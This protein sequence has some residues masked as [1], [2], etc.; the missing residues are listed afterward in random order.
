MDDLNK[1]PV[2]IKFVPGKTP[3]GTNCIDVTVNLLSHVFVIAKTTDY[4]GQAITA[5]KAF[6]E[7][8][9]ALTSEKIKIIDRDGEE[10]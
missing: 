8:L 10:I 7:L 3:S 9:I 6:K 5:A 4:E 2:F 1:T